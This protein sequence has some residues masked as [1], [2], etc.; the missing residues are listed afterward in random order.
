MVRASFEMWPR[1]SNCPPDLYVGASLAAQKLS[2][3]TLSDIKAL[4]KLV[5]PASSPAEMGIVIPCGAVNLKTCS[6]VCVTQTLVSQTLKERNHNVVW[7]LVS[8]I[9][10][11]L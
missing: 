5:D 4:N 9:I 7:L 1:A 8:L 6:V 10:L 2:K 11:S 3:V